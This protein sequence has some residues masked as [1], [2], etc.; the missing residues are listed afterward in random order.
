MGRTQGDRKEGGRWRENK[1]REKREGERSVAEQ[2]ETDR[3][4]VAGLLFTDVAMPGSCVCASE[5]A[6]EGAS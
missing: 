4:R 6:N 2:R 1:E 3:Q 5:R